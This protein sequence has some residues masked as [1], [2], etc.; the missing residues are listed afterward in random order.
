MVKRKRR[1]AGI[2]TRRG[3]ISRRIQ[4]IFDLA[5]A[6]AR[7]MRGK[8]VSPS[9][10]QVGAAAV[11]LQ[12]GGKMVL[13]YGANYKSAP[14]PR[15]HEEGI[16]HCAA[17]QALDDAGALG[18]GTIYCV[19]EV[20]K[21]Q[22]DDASGLDFKVLVSCVYCRV[23]FRIELQNPDSPLHAG[24][25]MRFLHP[26]N[27]SIIFMATLGKFLELFDASQDEAYIRDLKKGGR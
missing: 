19:S 1:K 7:L 4:R 20:G 13:A 23:R 6:S 10:K 5:D 25:W 8:G 9:G 24:T 11:I 18:R 26:T 3:R 15:K 16:D 22:R 21:P 27:H 14:G 17:M 12:P 2:A